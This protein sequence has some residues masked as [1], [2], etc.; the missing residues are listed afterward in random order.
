MDMK[1][2]LECAMGLDI[3]R[4]TI[5]A[6]LLKGELETRPEMEI[7]SFG[8]MIPEM[9]KL[10]TWVIETGCRYVAM[11]STGIYWQPVY[12]TL[13]ACFDGDM[14]LLVVNARHMKNV[15]G[16]KTDM[17]DS[18]WIAT[19]LR[20]GLLNGSFIPERPFRELRQL[21]RYRKNIQSDVTAQKNRIDKFLHSAGFRLSAFISD[22]FG[23]SG[24]NIMT[25]LCEHG[26]VDRAA[27]DKCLRNK[28]RL[29]MDDF[30]VSVNGT[31]SAH[32]RSCLRMML[33]YLVQ[34][35]AHKKVIEAAITDEVKNHSEA[36][37]L[38]CSI[39]GIDVI[40]G[41]AIIAEISTNMGHFP[42]AEH[43]CSWAGLCP[44][45]NESAGKRKSAYIT[46]GNPYLKSMLCEAA[47]V[48]AGKRK[49]YLANWYWRIKQQKCAK[50][51]TIALA[52]KLLVVIYTMLKNGTPY[53]ENIYEQRRQQCERKRANRL[54][55]ELAKLDYQVTPALS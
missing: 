44:G 17:R 24:R 19:L 42:S 8:T 37:T 48:I 12:E 2:L 10:R 38:L 28:T 11:E 55:H 27:L 1:D 43:I 31:L 36:L 13:E 50:R 22:I 30:L 6:C 20:A 7:R 35:E 45:N 26:S 3:H 34:I 49:T 47:W 40:S 4:D 16:K 23:A 46:K 14:H 51:A 15:P 39:P 32:Q 5:V 53:D 9:Q 33:D 54:I 25:H 52:R 21:T 41:T 18:E 29:R